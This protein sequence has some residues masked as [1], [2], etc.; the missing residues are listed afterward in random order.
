M[1]RVQKRFMYDRVFAA[2]ANHPSS[3]NV[4]SLRRALYGVDLFSSFKIMNLEGPI[5]M[6]SDLFW[7]A[8][9]PNNLTG[10]LCRFCM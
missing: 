3:S 9:I 10:Q 6:S 1:R 7:L 5:A 2:V 8:I 4:D